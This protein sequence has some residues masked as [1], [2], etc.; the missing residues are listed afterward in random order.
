MIAKVCVANRGEIAVRVMR[1]AADQGIGTVGQWI[2]LTFASNN[3]FV[4]NISLPK[5]DLTGGADD[6][7]R[8]QMVQ[9]PR[10]SHSEHDS[11]HHG[12]GEFTAKLILQL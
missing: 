8:E 10:A 5:R 7:E 12:R 3:R 6:Q 2:G 4:E 11:S 9:N 1:T